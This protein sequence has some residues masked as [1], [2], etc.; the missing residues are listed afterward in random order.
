VPWGE[1][2]AAA[3]VDADADIPVAAD[4]RVFVPAVHVDHHA[5]HV[6]AVLGDAHV[7]DAAA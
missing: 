6:L 1:G 3:G 7:D 4:Q 5:D 2:G